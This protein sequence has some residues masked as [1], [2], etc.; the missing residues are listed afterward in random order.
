VPP[1]D[2]DELS[3]EGEDGLVAQII[4]LRQ[5]EHEA[6]EPSSP[7]PETLDDRFPSSIDV[8][9]GERSVWDQP[10][11]ELR[12][13]TTGDPAQPPT[14]TALVRGG[15]ARSR[16]WLVA[17][18]VVVVVSAAVLALLLG[19]AFRG[20]PG[21]AVRQVGS[22]ASSANSTASSRVTTVSRSLA[23]PRRA[24]GTTGGT[25][26]SQRSR[27]LQ[28]HRYHRPSPPNA[29]DTSSGSSAA[30]SRTLAP[31]ANTEG[32]TT[33]SPEGSLGNRPGDSA[34]AQAQSPPAP[35]ANAPSTSQ[36][37]CVPGELGC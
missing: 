9:L 15:G 30:N 23:R 2:G 5:R 7:A 18:P 8:P 26:P 25:R 22:S 10:T 35:S 33:S 24:P 1:R 3:S 16:R 21:P 37:Q 12:R 4:P 11:A 13:R 17:V 19:S 14:I 20:Q 34:P 6:G 27:D 29:G 31:A 36:S 32:S 28:R